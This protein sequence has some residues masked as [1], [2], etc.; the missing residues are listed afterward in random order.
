MTSISPKVPV[1]TQAVGWIVLVAAAGWFLYLVNPLQQ[2]GWLR[3]P[4]NLMTGFYCPGCGSL[5]AI[6][7]LL[8]GDLLSAVSNNLLAVIA[9]PVLFGFGIRGIVNNLKGK[10]SST[11]ASPAA[12]WLVFWTVIGFAVIRNLPFAA[13]HFLRP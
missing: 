10:T 2:L 13:M 6:H 8:N 9:L 12:A 5:R 1:K 3:C 11:P 4:V 7:A